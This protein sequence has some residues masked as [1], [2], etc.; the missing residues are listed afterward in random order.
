MIKLIAYSLLWI[1]KKL[2]LDTK[3]RIKNEIYMMTTM[4]FK[5]LSY[6]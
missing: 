3:K 4:V 2:E 1:F 5:W 6:S